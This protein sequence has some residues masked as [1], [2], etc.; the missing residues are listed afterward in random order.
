MEHSHPFRPLKQ[1][2]KN[3]LRNVR[4]RLTCG[5]DCVVHSSNFR[6]TEDRIHRLVS[7]A[8]C[9]GRLEYKTCDSPAHPRRVIHTERGAEAT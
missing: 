8:M 1:K 4:V 7:H 9:Q 3:F 5:H 2:R 6:L